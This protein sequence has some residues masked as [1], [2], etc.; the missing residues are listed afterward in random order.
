MSLEMHGLILVWTKVKSGVWSGQ[1]AGMT[2]TISQARGPGFYV[3][4]DIRRSPFAMTR[5]L[6]L[7][8]TMAEE[9]ATDQAQKRKKSG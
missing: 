5:S 2:Y 8:K 7:A 1:G 4:R 6:S 3:T 9:D